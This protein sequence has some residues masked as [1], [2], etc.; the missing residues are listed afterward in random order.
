MRAKSG[1]ARIPCWPPHQ[2]ASHQAI[3]NYAWPLK[4]VLGAC[5]ELPTLPFPLSWILCYHP[6]SF[7]EAGQ[8]GVHLSCP[9]EV[10][11]L[12]L[13]LSGMQAWV[14]GQGDKLKAC[15]R[16]QLSKAKN[17]P[18]KGR[19]PM[20]W[21]KMSV[22]RENCVHTLSPCHQEAQRNTGVIPL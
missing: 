10:E 18:G 19:Q 7:F 6:A 12:R 21:R 5:A 15:P 9:G 3:R 8:D 1:I 16:L 22:Q 14:L 13:R 2:P 20:S 11:T 17:Q 4:S